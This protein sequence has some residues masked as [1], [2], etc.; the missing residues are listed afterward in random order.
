MTILII[1]VV[2]TAGVWFG[3]FVS[4]CCTVAG[5]RG[6]KSELPKVENLTMPEI[7]WTKENDDV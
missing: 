5:E 1:A 3:F 2:F 4:A 7:E 6:R